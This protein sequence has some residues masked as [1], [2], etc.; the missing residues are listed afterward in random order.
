MNNENKNNTAKT[1][2]E[3]W[4]REGEG[5]TENKIINN[6]AS[7]LCKKYLQNIQKLITIDK[8]MINNIRN[9]SNEDKMDIIIEFNDIVENLKVFMVKWMF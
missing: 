1:N 3:I 6:N 5:Y 7:D 4:W 8:E 2:I 9:M